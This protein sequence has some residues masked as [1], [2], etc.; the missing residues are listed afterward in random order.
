VCACVCCVCVFAR[1]C[2]SVCVFVCVCMCVCVCMFGCVCEI[3]LPPLSLNIF[4]AYVFCACVFTSVC[5]CVEQSKQH[6]T[7]HCK[8]SRMHMVH[9]ITYI[10]YAMA[11]YLSHLQWHYIYRGS[12]LHVIAS[13]HSC[14]WDTTSHVSHLYWH[15]VH[16]ICNRITYIPFAMALYQGSILHVIVRNHACTWDTTHAQREMTHSFLPQRS[17]VTWLT[18]SC[19]STCATAEQRDMTHSLLLQHLCYS[20]TT[21]RDSL[22]L[23]TSLVLQRNNVTRLTHSYYSTCAI[24]DMSLSHV[25]WLTSECHDVAG[26]VLI[27]LCPL[28]L[29]AMTHSF[30]TWLTPTCHDITGLAVILLCPLLLYDM[31]HPYL[32]SLVHMLQDSLPH[33]MT[34]QHVETHCNTLHHTS[35]RHDNAGLLLLLLCCVSAYLFPCRSKF[36][37]VSTMPNFATHTAAHCNTLHHIYYYCVHY[38]CVYRP[39]YFRSGRIFNSQLTAKKKSTVSSLPSN[40]H[41]NALQHTAPQLILLCPLL[42]CVLAYLFPYR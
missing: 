38:S 22:T 20:G 28:L 6:T 18:H 31:T 35:A 9:D 4:C 25:T 36:S 11:L 5:V 1:V 23:N 16:P 24:L 27:Q 26:L 19:N 21:W 37:T 29:C 39:I 3:F 40:T 32:T 33:D 34:M 42:L 2:V 10:P 30:V 17:N 8:Q 13:N 12:I 14:T 41:C 15:H 7:C